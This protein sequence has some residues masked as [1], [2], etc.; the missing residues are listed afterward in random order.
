MKGF[1]KTAVI[2][3][4]LLG[5]GGLTGCA[6]KQINNIERSEMSGIT[7]D[8]AGVSVVINVKSG[9]TSDYGLQKESDGF[10]VAVDSGKVTGEIISD[11]EYNNLMANYYGDDSYS[12]VSVQGLEGFAYTSAGSSSMESTGAADTSVDDE[13]ASPD[14]QDGITIED[15]NEQPKDVANVSG[16][17]RYHVFCIDKDD[18]IFVKMCSTAGDDALYQAEDVLEFSVTGSGA[19]KDTSETDPEQ[20]NVDNVN[21]TETDDQQ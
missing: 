9:S 1:K 18:S 8:D 10:S 12:N 20:T 13:V 16:G 11:L 4:L 2:L 17:M 14:D 3:S 5:I 19:A 15:M 21:N 7:V 6:G